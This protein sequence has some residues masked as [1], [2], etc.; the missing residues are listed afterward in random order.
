MSPKKDRSDVN[1]IGSLPPDPDNPV[2]NK[3]AETTI[4]KSE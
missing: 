3:D 2:I 4:A 1:N